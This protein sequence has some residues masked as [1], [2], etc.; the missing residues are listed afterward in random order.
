MSLSSI[1]VQQREKEA[2]ALKSFLAFS[3]LGSLA[4]HIGLL[5]SG[6]GNFLSRTPDLE[7]EPMEVVVVDP[8][9]VE[10]VKPEP[11]PQLEPQ[12][13][14]AQPSKAP[15]VASPGSS[16][17]GGQSAARGDV[18][19]VRSRPSP[20]TATKTP[21]PP[22][23]IAPSKAIVAE[24]PQPKAPPPIEKPAQNVKPEPAPVQKPAPAPEIAATPKPVQTPPPAVTNQQLRNT[25]AEARAARESQAPPTTTAPS[26]PPVGNTPGSQSV[27]TGSSVTRGNTF[28]TGR[29]TSSGSVTGTGSGT[30][31]GNSTG[32]G[33]SNQ[34]TAQGRGRGE[35]DAEGTGSG[36]LACRDCGKPKY[37]ESA[38]RKG[39]EGTAKVKLEVDDRGNVTDVKIAQSSGNEALDKEAVRAARRW[40]LKNPKGGTQGVVAKVDFELEKSERSRRSRERREREA[41]RKKRQQEAASSSRPSQAAPIQQQ[42]QT[43]PPSAS[44]PAVSNSPS[45]L[46]RALSLPQGE[47]QPNSAE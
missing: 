25:L 7:D 17:I 26:A 8:P 29:A 10:E 28:G 9:K 43:Q 11:K 6:I 27:A 37:P 38:R 34:G 1:A 24:K 13:Q 18:E 35:G 36:R 33:N 30:G 21:S 31:T 39:I 16:R 45:R 23:R 5:A 42:E 20:P 12:R 15:V 14:Q 46:Q 19:V 40:K 32:S 47:S 3:L 4:L 2:K 22:P 41:A 44:Q